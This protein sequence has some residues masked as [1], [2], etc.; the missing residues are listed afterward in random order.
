MG[1]QDVSTDKVD[2]RCTHRLGTRAN[3]DIPVGGCIAKRFRWGV[4]TAYKVGTT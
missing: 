3:I 4:P 2:M 1:D